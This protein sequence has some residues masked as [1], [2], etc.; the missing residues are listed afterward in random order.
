LLPHQ[1]GQPFDGHKAAGAG[2]TDSQLVT[3]VDVLP[4]NAPDNAEARVLVE[5]S[6]K[7][8][9]YGVEKP[10]EIA[11]MEMGILGMLL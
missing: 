3:A 5:K 7:N 10:W 2:D 11:P 8:I 1:F 6:E 4:G 9:A